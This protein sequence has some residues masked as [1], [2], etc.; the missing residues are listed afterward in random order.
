MPTTTKMRPNAGYHQKGFWSYRKP[1]CKAFLTIDTRSYPMHFSK[2]FVGELRKGNP[3]PYEEVAAV[4]ER[5]CPVG[6]ARTSGNI[7]GKRQ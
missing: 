6:G 7:A 4:F 1:L 5:E 3:L 2:N